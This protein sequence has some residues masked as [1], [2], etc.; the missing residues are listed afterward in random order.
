METQNLETVDDY[1]KLILQFIG[2]L[3]LAD[4]L[5]DVANDTDTVL[6]RLGLVIQ[7]EE[8][9]ELQNKLRRMGVTTLHGTRL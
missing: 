9:F 7:W 8:W 3:S 5:G 2:S 4:H 1:R 6:S